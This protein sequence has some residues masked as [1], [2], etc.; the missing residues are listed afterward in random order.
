MLRFTAVSL[1]DLDN[2]AS[3]PPAA[4]YG[5]GTKIWTRSYW[6]WWFIVDFPIENGDF[7]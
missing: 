2:D 4:W 7:P 5:I 3:H 6:K 1:D